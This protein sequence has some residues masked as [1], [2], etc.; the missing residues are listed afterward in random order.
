M[1]G[2]HM[3]K[4]W[5][6]TQATDALSSAE[7]ELYATVKASAESLGIISLLNDAGRDMRAYVFGDAGAALGIIARRRLGKVRHLNT[8]YL[9]VQEKAATEEI[10]YGKTQGE[11]NTADLFTKPL[12]W[13]TVLYHTESMNCKLAE[14]RDSMGYQV[15]SI[16]KDDKTR[17]ISMPR[18]EGI[19]E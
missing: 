6:R 17:K 11:K 1:L 3:I 12:D 7:A 8:S 15:A 4:M 13:N 16:S 18:P 14:G 2:Q 5:S 19:S 9:W 10:K